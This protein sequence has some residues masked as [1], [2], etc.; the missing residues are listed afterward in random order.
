MAYHCLTC[1]GNTHFAKGLYNNFVYIDTYKDKQIFIY[2]FI[3]ICVYRYTENFQGATQY[4]KGY[5]PPI[6]K[7][8]T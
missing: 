5:S 1:P 6:H 4:L 3:C 7:C 8:R 2:M